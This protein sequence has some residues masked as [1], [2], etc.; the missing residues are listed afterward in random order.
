MDCRVWGMTLSW[1]GGCCS[2]E[3]DEEGILSEGG[4]WEVSD[5]GVTEVWLGMEWLKSEGSYK[6]DGD[7]ISI[8][9]RVRINKTSIWIS[10]KKIGGKMK[11][12]FMKYDIMRDKNI[13]AIQIEKLISFHSIYVDNQWRHKE[14]I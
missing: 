4:V 1:V 12:V 5:G 8:S 11:H 6:C 13:L 2:E 14:W 7:D 9:D 10:V 3:E